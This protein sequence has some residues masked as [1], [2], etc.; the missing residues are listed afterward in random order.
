MCHY[1]HPE[2]V[3]WDFH[4]PLAEVLSQTGISK[5]GHYLEH[6]PSLQIQRGMD[7][8]HYGRTI[9]PDG[10]R[11]SY[12]SKHFVC[13]HCH[14]TVQEDPDLGSRDPEKRLEYA[15]EKEIPFL[16]GTTF[17]GIVNRTSWYNGDYVK[18][19]GD[20]V[21]EANLDLRKAIQ[22]CAVECSQGREL[23][24]WE[25]EAIL[26]YFRTLEVRLGDLNLSTADLITINQLRYHADNRIAIQSFIDSVFLPYSPAT[27]ADAPEDKQA[28]YDYVGDTDRGRAIYRLSC[29]H[30]H[31]KGGVSR[32]I[33]D[34][35]TLSFRHLTQ[36][37]PQNS[38]MSLYQI[39]RYGT[40]AV[41]GHRPYMPHYPLERMSHQQ[42]EDL[43]AYIELM[44][45]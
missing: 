43:R 30:C 27:F 36:K 3:S 15:I 10:K 14:N 7:L 12:I 20:Q 45:I 19:Y 29:M 5:P 39:I 37:I 13:T 25:I 33:L 40:Y 35:S 44:A 28:G 24:T 32:Y 38:H 2:S 17:H 8:V 42:V 31:R 34:Y 41:P 9:G 18:K 4:T 1:T 16:Q 21:N 6:A 11:T 26:A 23:E 22:L